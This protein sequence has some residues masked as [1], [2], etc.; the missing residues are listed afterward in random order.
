[1]H[2]VR[3]SQGCVLLAR[4]FLFPDAH[5]ST[6]QHVSVIEVCW[7]S[8]RSGSRSSDIE[9]IEQVFMIP[10]FTGPLTQVTRLRARPFS[11]VLMRCPWSAQPLLGYLDSR[12]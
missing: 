1:M 5:A 3:G 7:F 8:I 11:I 10:S 4:V 9:L 2:G 12:E 6:I